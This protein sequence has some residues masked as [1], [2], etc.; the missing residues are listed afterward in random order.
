MH[1]GRRAN[2]TSRAK[3]FVN[4]TKDAFGSIIKT[5][6]SLEIILEWLAYSPFAS[7]SLQHSSSSSA[8]KRLPASTNDDDDDLPYPSPPFARAYATASQRSGSTCSIA[9]ASIS[10]RYTYRTNTTAGDN[11]LDEV[12]VRKLVPRSLFDQ[13]NKTTFTIEAEFDEDYL[14]Q[15]SDHEDGEDDEVL[16]IRSKRGRAT[17]TGFATS[18]PHNQYSTFLSQS[19]YKQPYVFPRRS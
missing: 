1:L 10:S 15:E 3:S 19:L 16:L 7:M 8:F 12:I 6:K 17:Q 11:F 13:K 5:F 4:K 14:S 9:A 2:S 18:L